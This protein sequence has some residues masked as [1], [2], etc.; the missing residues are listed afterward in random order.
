MYDVWTAVDGRVDIGGDERAP[1]WMRLGM[2]DPAPVDNLDRRWPGRAIRAA[3]RRS[4]GPDK[5]C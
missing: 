1:L 3:A 2:G 4:H 5:F